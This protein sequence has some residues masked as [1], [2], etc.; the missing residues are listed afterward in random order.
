VKETKF[1]F[2]VSVWGE[3]FL[4]VFLDYVL[5][6][7]LASG[8]LPSIAKDHACAYGI[9]VKPEEYETVDSHWAY[10]RLREI[11]PVQIMAV[12][13]LTG[14]DPYESVRPFHSLAAE[15]AIEGSEFLITLPPDM[16]WANHSFA[17][18]GKILSTNN[19]DIL[20]HSSIR[21][22][23]SKLLAALNRRFDVENAG[24][25]EISS[26]ELV[27]LNFQNIHAN[28][29]L[30]DWEKIPRVAAAP[31][32]LYFMVSAEA[33]VLRSF[34]SH[35]LAV[36]LLKK[37]NSDQ[38]V[39]PHYLLQ[40]YL[41]LDNIVV[42]SDSDVA[43]GTDL[44]LTEKVLFE[45]IPAPMMPNFVWQWAERHANAIH[46]KIFETVVFV[47]GEGSE[48]LDWQGATANCDDVYLEIHKKLNSLNRDMAH[49]D[50]PIILARTKF[51]LL[52]R[53]YDLGYVARLEAVLTLG[54]Y[55]LARVLDLTWRKVGNLFRRM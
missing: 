23:Q 36:K 46:R 15:K 54:A 20:F 30:M 29:E 1:Y 45:T 4:S 26:R 19:I 11:I 5:P 13:V 28:S 9:F 38:F 27:S 35:P 50:A 12:P 2:S 21:S 42:I 10:R 43:Y 33:C 51:H 22:D 41:N 16:L 39:N 25:L 31:H 17:N 53:G 55:Y 14:L 44:T 6:S 49:E 8:N 48:I 3:E 34:Y 24:R 18:I 47:R 40:N 52:D 32:H 37:S 7:H